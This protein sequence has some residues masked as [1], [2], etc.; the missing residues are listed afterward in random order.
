MS[1]VNSLQGSHRADWYS[2]WGFLVGINMNVWSYFGLLL[3]CARAAREAVA[4][5]R[6]FLHWPCLNPAQVSYSSGSFPT[7]TF[8]FVC[9]IAK[10]TFPFCKPAW[11]FSIALIKIHL[12]LLE[13]SQS[14]CL[15]PVRVREAQNRG[16]AHPQKRTSSPHTHCKF[17]APKFHS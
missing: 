8:L 2:R 17:E 11:P 14:F 15:S 3:G 7:I 6:G 9:F 16:P 13:C 10:N 4:G 1:A 12:W 5:K